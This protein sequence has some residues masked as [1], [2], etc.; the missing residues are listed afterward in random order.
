MEMDRS[1]LGR[2]ERLNYILGGILVAVT[3]ATGTR[4]QLL[5]ALVGAV[6]AAVNFSLLRR[7]VERMA[8][9]PGGEPGGDRG[10]STMAGL[11]ILPKML[12]L[13][14]AVALALVFLPISAA[15][16]AVGFS[17]FLLS[18]GVETVRYVLGTLSRGAD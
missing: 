2:I 14:G 12:G 10:G 18:I 16:L 13:M 17:V 15:M 1:S 7:I 3:A 4:E 8:P 9:A 11:A 5:G 6:L